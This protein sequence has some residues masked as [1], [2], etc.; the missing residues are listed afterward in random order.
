MTTNSFQTFFRDDPWCG[1]ERGAFPSAARR[2]YQEDDRFWVSIDIQGR[3]LFFA[4]EVGDYTES[5]PEKVA[6]VEIEHIKNLNGKTRACCILEDDTL[7]D[8]FTLVAKDVAYRCSAFQGQEFFNNIYKRISSWGSFL[9]PERTGVGF[10]KLIGFFSELYVFKTL[11]LNSLAP[12]E[13]VKSWGGPEGSNQ[14]FLWNGVSVE[15]KSTLQGEKKIIKISSEYQLDH[16]NEKCFLLHVCLSPTA[17]TSG[18][19][20]EEI[21]EEIQ[22]NLAAFPEALADFRVKSGLTYGKMSLAEIQAKFIV[23]EVQAYLVD[24]NFPK[25]TRSAIEFKEISNVKYNV[26]ITSLR[27][28]GTALD[29]RQEIKHGC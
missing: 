13:A 17:Q 19:S 15:V 10:K 2:L 18:S 24:D 8:M 27:A 11:F 12:N 7:Q 20:A 26:D 4:Q 16:Q 1:I 9:K 22:R 3:R 29:L 6:F 28:W 23:T 25:L 14:D 5:L 21:I